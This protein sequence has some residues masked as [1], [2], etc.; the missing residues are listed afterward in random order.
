ME[1]GDGALE[2]DPTLH[3]GHIDNSSLF[4]KEDPDEVRDHM[5]ET[6]DYYLL[7]KEGWD[8]LVEE[9]GT[10]PGQEPIARK[11]R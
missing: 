3:P 5:V 4:S 9:F 1:P 11:V 6:M 2:G 7:P 8:E 10:T